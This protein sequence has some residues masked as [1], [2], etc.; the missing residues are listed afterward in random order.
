MGCCV[1]VAF[2]HTCF[3]GDR[4]G[5]DPA[6]EPHVRGICEGIDKVRCIRYTGNG[7]P[8]GVRSPEI[9]GAVGVAVAAAI[10]TKR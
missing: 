6:P 5:G 10:E 9:V 3:V 7:V 2:V 4:R 8:E 1:S